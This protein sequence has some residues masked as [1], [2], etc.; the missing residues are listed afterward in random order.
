MRRIG[1]VLTIAV[2]ALAA[3]SSAAAEKPSYGCPPGFNIG[4]VN[5]DDYIQLP[6]TDAAIEAG[7]TTEQ[8][9]RGFLTQ[10][11]KNANGVVCV[12]LSRG[13]VEGNNPFGEFFY[14][15]VDDNA[16]TPD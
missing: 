15:L 12:Q 9:V 10:V 6:R 2:L 14:N 5:F 3:A 16:A 13:K 8:E 7:L 4:A 1:L 11:D